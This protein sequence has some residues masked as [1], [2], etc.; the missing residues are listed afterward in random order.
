MLKLNRE[1]GVTFL[2][3]TH[4][5]RVVAH[6]R[7]ALHIQDGKMVTGELPGTGA[8]AAGSH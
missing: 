8:K 6:A 7:R 3:S 5:P 2:F 4:D 1:K